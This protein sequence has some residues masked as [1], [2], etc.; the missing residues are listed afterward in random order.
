[1]HF[2]EREEEKTREGKK[3][4]K[5]SFGLLLFNDSFRSSFHKKREKD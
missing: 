2:A 3:M 1:M 4:F 5:I